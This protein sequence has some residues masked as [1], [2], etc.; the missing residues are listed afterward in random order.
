MAS[1]DKKT[2]RI[3]I[4][5]LETCTSFA[6]CDVLTLDY[7]DRLLELAAPRG[8]NALTLFILPDSYYPETSARKH[9]EYEVG[10]DWPSEAYAQYRNPH[11]PNAHPDTEYVPELIR[12]C[13]RVDVK[14][15][16]RTINNKHRWLF[17]EHDD[18]R[19]LQLQ[20]DGSIEPSEACCWDIP[21]FMEYYYGHLGELIQRYTSDQDK[22]D[23]IILDQQKCFGP[24]VNTE[25]RKRFRKIMGHEMD[26]NKPDE[27]MEYWS[28]RNAQRVK[29]T[30]AFCK[31]ILP[32][33]EVGVTLEA[34]KRVHFDTGS[35]GMLHRLFN[36]RTTGVDFIHHQIIDHSED[37]CFYIWEQLCNEGP[38]WIMLDPTAADAG[39]NKGYWGWTPR[40]PDSIREEVGKVKRVRN[41]LSHPENLVGITEFPISR[42]PLEHPNLA[43][44]MEHIGRG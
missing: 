19:A 42:L 31:T 3:P 44:C 38:T 32:S 12:R 5:A 10:L 6:T 39:W 34:E 16:L 4:R 1:T 28:I 22:A 21:E 30:V 40:T 20:P 35:T 13:H 14:F 23:G 15:Y 18:W 25:S 26:L 36:H 27:I 11:C 2:N 9:W 24:Y 8:V 7:F 17:P 37:E 33:L 43:A 41:R 29:E